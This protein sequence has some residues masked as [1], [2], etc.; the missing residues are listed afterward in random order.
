VGRPEFHVQAGAYAHR[1]FADDLGR[2]LRANGYTV[3]LGEGPLTRVWVGA[4]MSREA[5][6]RLA[7]DLRLKGFE[8]SLSP[9][10]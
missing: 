2:R 4:A 1:E 10:Q 3:T 8:A 9:V 7:A 5:A 6:Q